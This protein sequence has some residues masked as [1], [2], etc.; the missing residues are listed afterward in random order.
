MAVRTALLFGTRPQLCNITTTDE[1]K[2]PKFLALF[3]LFIFD[4]VGQTLWSNSMDDAVCPEM[5]S[6]IPLM[7]FQR[8]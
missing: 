4:T 7:L 2:P 8:I 6:V 1:V 5:K 3:T